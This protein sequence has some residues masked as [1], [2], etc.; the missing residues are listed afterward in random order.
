M[1]LYVEDSEAIPAVKIEADAVNSVPGYTEKT[2]LADWDTYGIKGVG[3]SEL[4]DIMVLRSKIKSVYEAIGVPVDADRIIASKWFVVDKSVRDL[5]KSDDEQKSDAEDLSIK[6]FKGFGDKF[7]STTVTTIKGADTVV[8][9]QCIDNIDSQ[10]WK[11][12]DLGFSDGAFSGVS[13]FE[14]TNGG[15]QYSFDGSSND[16]WSF[17]KKL[18]S[19]SGVDYD[20]S[21]I[22]VS[23]T[24]QQSSASDADDDVEWIFTYKFIDTPDD[25]DGDGTTNTDTLVVDNRVTGTTYTDSLTTLTGVAGKKWLMGTLERNTIGATTDTLMASLWCI[26]ID[27]KKV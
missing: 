19:E 4:P 2:S 16:K 8:V 6:L 3:Q 10:Q 25:S 21:D 18:R 22:S 15:L 20:G 1:R 26:D 27:F 12:P 7:I 23:I 24:S 17:T 13:I 5:V 14:A 9:D 11:M